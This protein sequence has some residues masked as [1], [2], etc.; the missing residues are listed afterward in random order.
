MAGEFPALGDMLRVF[1]SRQIRNRATMGGNLVTASPI[2]DSA[3]LLLALD[4][5][6]VL[7]SRSKE[8]KLGV[9][10][11]RSKTGGTPVLLGTHAAARR[12]L[13]RLP[14]DCPAARARSSR[15]SSYPGS[16]QPDLTVSA[17]GTRC[18]SGA[19]WTSARWRRASGWIW[20]RTGSFRR[21]ARLRRR[22]GNAR[23]GAQDRAGSARQ[24]VVRGDRSAGPAD[25]T[26]VNSRRSRIAR[27]CR[28]PARADYEL[29]REVL[30]QRRSGGNEA[31]FLSQVSEPRSRLLRCGP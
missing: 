9:L 17:R 30:L 13:R 26:E 15:P 6:V 2:G 16:L 29:V 4:A 22:G 20:V 10:T 7:V 12:V 28:I 3:P 5:K 19:R 31:H 18:R 11:F 25:P 21:T 27:Q 14:Q 8:G 1:G 23:A 24:A